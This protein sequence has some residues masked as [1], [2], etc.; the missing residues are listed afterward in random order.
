MPQ[1]TGMGINAAARAHDVLK[2]TLKDRISGRVVH[3]TK[4]EPHQY[5]KA[6]EVHL[7]WYLGEISHGKTCTSSI[8]GQEWQ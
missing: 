2:T 5:L 1:K 7:T 3:G 6:E 4:P 8:H